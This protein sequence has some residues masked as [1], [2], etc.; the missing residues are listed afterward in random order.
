MPHVADETE[1]QPEPSHMNLNERFYSTQF[2]S[3]TTTRFQLFEGH[4]F[5]N[6]FL[7]LS[8]T[9]PLAKTSMKILPVNLN[10]ASRSLWTNKFSEAM[11]SSDPHLWKAATTEEYESLMSNKILY[12]SPLP[13]N[14]TSIKSGWV[15]QVKPGVHGLSP[16]Y[17]ARLVESVLCLLTTTRDWL[18]RNLLTSCKIWHS[19]IKS[20]SCFCSWFRYVVVGY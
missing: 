4:V 3:N 12:L 18:W 16:R 2:Y 20:S 7:T 19:S 17:K 15:F 8:F 5:I 6:A 10:P 13:P 9:H 11:E 1:I 14:R